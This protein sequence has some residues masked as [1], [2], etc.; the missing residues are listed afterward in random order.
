M[1]FTSTVLTLLLLTAPLVADDIFLKGDRSILDVR[2]TAE[3]YTEVS[4]KT[5]RGINQTEPS[6]N[7]LRCSY[8]KTSRDF[9]DGMKGVNTP[10]YQEA[11]RKLQWAADDEELDEFKRATA[12]ATA[13]GALLD[14]GYYADAQA[15]YAE[16]LAEYRKTRHRPRALLGNAK[17]LLNLGRFA[18]ADELLRTLQTE[19]GQK[20]F[21]PE[22]PQEAEFLLLFSAEA[23]GASGDEVLSGYKDLRLLTQG[24]Y[25]GIANKCALRIGRLMF[26]Q[27]NPDLR[28]SERLFEEIIE[29]RFGTDRDIVAGAYNGRGRVRFMSGQAALTNSDP[30]RAREELD[31]ALLDFLRVVV[32][33]EQISNEQPEAL[34][35]A[36]K[37]FQSLAPLGGGGAEP[38]LN[39]RRLLNTLRQSEKYRKSHWA[40]EAAKE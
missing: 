36:A 17:A 20:G 34:Y 8:N 32:S 18:E 16:L 35:W 19:S 11:I 29:K 6:V 9:N 15:N 7:V 39:G 33:F 28:G 27:N 2:I 26:S 10:S 38:E 37:S 22:W 23:Q 21:A 24:E 14:N 3:D 12:L 5:K 13:A 25:D 4:Y 1:K 30:E 40:Q 31:A